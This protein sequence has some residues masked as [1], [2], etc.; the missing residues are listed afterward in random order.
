MLLNILDPNREVKP[1][2]VTYLL[3][4]TQ[5]RTITGLIKE[6]NANSITIARADG[7]SDTVLR[8][9]I[10]E[11]ISSRLSFMPEG[12]E[13]QINKQEMADLLAYLNSIK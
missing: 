12:L 11:L 8:I 3:V 13:K 5:G 4:T 1:Q 6:E 2:Y 9:D 7:T 10:D